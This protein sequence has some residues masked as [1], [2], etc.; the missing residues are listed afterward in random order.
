MADIVVPQEYG[1]TKE[2]KLSIGL[3]ICAPLLKK[4]RGDLLRDYNEEENENVN[5]LNPIYSTGVAS[6]GRLVKTRL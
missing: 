2:E 6:P 4:I 5:R 1:M 3:G